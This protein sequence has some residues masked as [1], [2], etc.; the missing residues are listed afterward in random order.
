V[1][2][3]VEIKVRTIYV[4]VLLSI[5]VGG[6]LGFTVSYV[7][8]IGRIKAVESGLML[9]I[10]DLRSDVKN[11]LTRKVNDLYRYITDVKNDLA[12]SAKSLRDDIIAARIEFAAEMKN[13]SDNIE[14][15]VSSINAKISNLESYLE[16]LSSNVKS[17][18]ERFAEIESKLNFTNFQTL[19]ELKDW[20]EADTTDQHVYILGE[21]DCEDFA[22]NLMI[23]AFKSRKIVGTVI[24]HYSDNIP[25]IERSDGTYW[26]VHRAYSKSPYHIFGSHMMNIAYVETRGWV[27]IEPQTDQV[28]PLDTYEL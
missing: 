9:E 16:T 19:K 5:F 26:Q 25:H 6:L 2:K 8:L 20:L 24:V 23:N 17:M 14:K 28:I 21:Y 4:A 10:E 27:L 1:E 15:N 22:F 11:N 3:R 7:V 13:L 12:R 18:E